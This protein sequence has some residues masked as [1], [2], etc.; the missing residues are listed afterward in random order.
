MTSHQPRSP[1]E[2]LKEHYDHAELVCQECGFEDEAGTWEASTDGA[3]IVYHHTCPKCGAER[4]H[5]LKLSDSD[6]AREHAQKR[7]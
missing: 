7:R 3:T 6:A 5:S 1:F 4:V 2:R